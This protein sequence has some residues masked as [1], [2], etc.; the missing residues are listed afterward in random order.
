MNC[1]FTNL[2]IYLTYFPQ[3]SVEGATGRVDFNE[4]GERNFFTLRFME[5]TPSG[6]LDLATWDPVNGVDALEKEDASE[7]RVGEKLSNKTFIITSRI[8]APFLLNR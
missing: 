3:R 8:G 5:L 4:H 6:F 1:D 2:D 7:K